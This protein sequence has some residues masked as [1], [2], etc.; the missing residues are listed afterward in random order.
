MF[1]VLHI[2]RMFNAFVLLE[3]P[4]ALIVHRII[5]IV[6]ATKQH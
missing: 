5:V 2:K 3:I 6:V 1:Y 4:V